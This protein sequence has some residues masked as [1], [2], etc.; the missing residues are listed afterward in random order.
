MGLMVPIRPSTDAAKATAFDEEPRRDFER[1]ILAF[2]RTKRRITRD[3]GVA[4][5]ARVFRGTRIPVDH[6]VGLLERGV[7]NAEVLAD[8]PSLTTRDLETAHL[9]RRLGRRPGRPRRLE[10]K[11]ADE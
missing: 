2:W 6:V 8:L 7:S 5:G 9:E 3:P 4:G 11:P 10:L 1:S